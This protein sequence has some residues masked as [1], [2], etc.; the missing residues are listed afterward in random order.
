MSRLGWVSFPGGG[1]GGT[2]CCRATWN[3][4]LELRA[5]KVKG[6]VITRKRVNSE[7]EKSIIFPISSFTL[8]PWNPPTPSLKGECCAVQC[9]VA[10]SCPTLCHLMDYSPPGSSIHGILQ[11]TILEW[12]AIPFS[13][14][15]S[16]LRDQ[17]QVSCIAGR[18]FTVW[19]T[20][21]ALIRKLTPSNVHS[22]PG[23]PIHPVTNEHQTEVFIFYEFSG[24][25][26][27]QHPRH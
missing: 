1:E 13:R 6:R 27:Y 24:H 23:K 5:F 19:A 16:Q 15:S 8:Q 20:R 18:F 25:Q 10:H 9:L 22:L 21:E 14:G 12:L 3:E 4:L 11:A 26:F 17:T 7:Q 2:G